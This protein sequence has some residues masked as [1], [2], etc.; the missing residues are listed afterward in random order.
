MEIKEIDDKIMIKQT[1]LNLEKNPE[2]KRRLYNEL[3]ILRFRKDIEV[4]KQQ[5]NKLVVSK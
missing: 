3:N 4:I 5:I 2:K 1:E